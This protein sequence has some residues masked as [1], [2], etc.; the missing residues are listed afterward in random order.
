MF[1]HEDGHSRF[2]RNVGAYLPNCV[3]FLQTVLQEFRRLVAGILPQRPEFGPTQFQV[4]FVVDAVAVRW[5]N[6]Q[7][8]ST[9][10]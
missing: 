4:E 10:V 7:R 1:Y 9:A 6:L 2:V 8:E 3:T 5:S